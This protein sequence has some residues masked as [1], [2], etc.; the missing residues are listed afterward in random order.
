VVLRIRRVVL[1]PHDRERRSTTTYSDL[2]LVTS[3]GELPI[4]NGSN[5]NDSLD[6]GQR[7]SRYLGVDFAEERVPQGAS[8]DLTRQPLRLKILVGIVVFLLVGGAVF[9]LVEMIMVG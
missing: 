3:T 7:L 2:V 1:N 4:T 8:G 9:R 6:V 5:R